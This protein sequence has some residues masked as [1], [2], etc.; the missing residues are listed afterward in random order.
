MSSPAGHFLDYL[1]EISNY[2]KDKKNIM[3]C[4]KLEHIKNPFWYKI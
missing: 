3:P 1:F 2:F 4:I